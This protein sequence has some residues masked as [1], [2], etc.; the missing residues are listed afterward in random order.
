[1]SGSFAEDGDG[2]AISQSSEK[3]QQRGV[4][5]IEAVGSLEEPEKSDIIML[6]YELW[7]LLLS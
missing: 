2:H 7:P 5:L 6:R 4:H 3:T 1:M